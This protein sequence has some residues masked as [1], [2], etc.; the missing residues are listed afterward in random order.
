M[1]NGLARFISEHGKDIYK[2]YTAESGREALEVLFK[3]QPD[4]LIIDIQ[5]PYKDGLQVI[6]EANASGLHPKTIILSGYDRFIYAQQAIRLGV[7][8]YLLKPCRPTDLFAK[9]RELI[10]VE[11]EEQKAVGEKKENKNRIIELAIEY[12]NEHYMENLSLSVVAEHVSLS[13][14]YFSSLF[15]QTMDCSF[16]DYLNRVRVD[17]ACSYLFNPSLKTYEVAGKVGF[18]D[19]KYFSRIFKKVTGYTPSQFRKRES[20]D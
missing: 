17:H 20:Q 2:V 8:D 4:I 19:E 1:R 6:K 13:T 14:A 9:L 11:G 5:M 3:V 12:I 16:V 15:T 10:P 7:V 18:K